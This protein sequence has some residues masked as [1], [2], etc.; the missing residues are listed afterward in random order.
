MAMTRDKFQLRDELAEF[1]VYTCRD[2]ESNVVDST[3]WNGVDFKT[4]STNADSS[5]RDET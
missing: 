1:Y 5:L 3:Y 4:Y 2:D